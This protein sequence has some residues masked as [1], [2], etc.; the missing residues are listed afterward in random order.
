MLGNEA[1]DATIRKV[2]L[3]ESLACNQA[4]GTDILLYTLHAVFTP[5]Q[6]KWTHTKGNK[7]QAIK[8]VCGCDNPPPP[9]DPLAWRL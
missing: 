7:K 1:T 5:W 2:T 8:P 6:N 9:S 4:V 3:H